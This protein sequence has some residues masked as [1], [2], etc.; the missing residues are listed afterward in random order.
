M[1]Q[2]RSRSLI[3]LFS[4]PIAATLVFGVGAATRSNTP[5]D[6][7]LTLT[8]SLSERTLTVRKYG[9]VVKTYGVAIGSADHPTPRGSYGIRK[10]VWNPAWIPPDSKWAAG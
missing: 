9:E 7:P 10:I 3:A 5:E 2:R 6:S 4:V 1:M 8:T